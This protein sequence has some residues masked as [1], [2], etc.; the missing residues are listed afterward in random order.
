MQASLPGSQDEATGASGVP[1]WVLLGARHGDNQQLLAIAQALGRPFRTV[2]LRFNSIAR[3]APLLLG[4]SRWSWHSDEPLGPPWPRAVLAAGR[5]SVPAARWIRRRSGGRT[6]LVHVNRPWAPLSWFDLVITTPQYAL[7]PRDNVL[8]NLL[9]FRLPATMIT[10]MPASLAQRAGALPRPWTAVLVGGNSRPY[11]LDED[12]A[13]RLAQ[14]VDAAVRDSGGSAWVLDSPRTPPE[15]LAVVERRLSVPVQFVRWRDARNGYDALL[16]AADRFIVTADSASMLAEALMTGRPV[17]PFTL[18]V[19]HDRK[20]RIARAWEAAAQ[21][22][23]RS[24]LA[25]SFA[26]ARDLGLLTSLRDL[27]RLHD[28]LREAGAFSAP[29]AALELA[30]RER[31]RTLERI[32]D[33]VGDSP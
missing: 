20:S 1:I 16:A 31:R 13:E 18:P 27:A 14:A 3:K 4:A 33:V 6:R 32:A 26:W 2:H 11:V 5:R 28:A 17:T 7:P 9:P 29:G 23:P 22:S 10:P 15:A 25:R 24:L 19:R 8:A 12:A 30:E 21:R